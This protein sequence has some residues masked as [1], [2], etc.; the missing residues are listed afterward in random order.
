MVPQAAWLGARTSGS[1]VQGNG[2][3]FNLSFRRRKACEAECTRSPSARASTRFFE[4]ETDG[5]VGDGLDD[6]QVNQPCRLQAQQQPFAKG[7]SNGS[8]RADGR[9][10]CWWKAVV[11]SFS[12]A[13]MSRLRSY[14]FWSM[15]NWQRG[16]CTSATLAYGTLR[17]SGA[18]QPHARSAPKWIN[19]CSYVGLFHR[20]AIAPRGESAIP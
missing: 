12:R 8:S 11:G 15:M 20:R 7:S 3:S 2:T 4:G 14:P 16:R 9:S 19:L 13:G 1:E 10:R 18:D 17:P 5:L 6:L